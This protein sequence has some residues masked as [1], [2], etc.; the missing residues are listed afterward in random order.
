MATKRGQ[1]IRDTVR[2]DGNESHSTNGEDTPLTCAHC[3]YTGEGVETE[4]QYVGG[5]GDVTVSLCQDRV[6]CWH[7]FDIQNGL[8]CL[9]C[10]SHW[11]ETSPDGPHCLICGK[12][13]YP[14]PLPLVEDHPQH[15]AK[16]KELAGAVR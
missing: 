12:Y 4:S 7:R 1:A 10:G 9:K 8:A 14:K 2:E 5:K 6:S 11:L 16:R 15:Y 13:Q 3:G